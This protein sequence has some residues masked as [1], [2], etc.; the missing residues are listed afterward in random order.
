MV[1]IPARATRS[2]RDVI[3]G[4]AA[5]AACHFVGQLRHVGGHYTRN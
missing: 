5:V 3:V 2:C 4:A 1:A